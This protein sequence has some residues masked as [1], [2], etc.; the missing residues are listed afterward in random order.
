MGLY[1]YSYCAEQGVQGQ[2]KHIQCIK[3]KYLKNY[4][5]CLANIRTFKVNSGIIF[6]LKIPA[7]T[8]V[9]SLRNI[10]IIQ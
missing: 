10:G 3:K 6:R 2:T 4:I 7:Y 1:L 8:E 9:K 5:I